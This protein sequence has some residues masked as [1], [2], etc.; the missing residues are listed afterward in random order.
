[1][2]LHAHARAT[3]P[4]RLRGP[5]A[6]VCGSDPEGLGSIVGGSRPASSPAPVPV[7]LLVGD[8]GQTVHLFLAAVA[9]GMAV[10]DAL[11]T[12][13]QVSSGHF[14]HDDKCF[15]PENAA[16]V[17][18]ADRISLLHGEERRVVCGSEGQSDVTLFFVDGAIELLPDFIALRGTRKGGPLSRPRVSRGRS[19]GGVG[20]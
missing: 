18:V 17:P 11:A 6:D 14:S 20:D 7:P 2:R 10:V 13:A 5:V 19:A 12:F 3:G 16:L 4:L 15:F 8:Y 1:M 9:Q